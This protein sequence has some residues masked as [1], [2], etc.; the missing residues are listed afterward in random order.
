MKQ[1]HVS[2]G[3]ALVPCVL[4]PSSPAHGHCLCGV[5]SFSNFRLSK[6]ATVPAVIHTKLASTLFL[7]K[8]DIQARPLLFIFF[9]FDCLTIAL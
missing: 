5:T 1:R 8:P 6:H 4:W 3:N 9:D 7:T 2:L